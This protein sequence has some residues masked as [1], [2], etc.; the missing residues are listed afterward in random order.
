[1]IWYDGVDKVIGCAK[2]GVDIDFFGLLYGKVLR[3]LHVY[4]KIKSID[5]LVVL[6]VFGVKVVIIS[7]D[8]FDLFVGV[9]MMGELLMNLCYLF[10]NVLV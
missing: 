10:M 4:V 2:Y 3:S 7:V 5:V 8:L 9:A 1:M 6:V